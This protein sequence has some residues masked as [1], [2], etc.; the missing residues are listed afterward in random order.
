MSLTDCSCV[1][2]SS[3]V[4]DVTTLDSKIKAGEDAMARLEKRQE[5]SVVSTAGAIKAALAA[6]EGTNAARIEKAVGLAEGN[7]EGTLGGIRGRVE[8]LELLHHD[9]EESNR[10]VDD[11]CTTLESAMKARV[12]EAEAKA[13][14]SD[15][16]ILE[17]IGRFSEQMSTQA[18]V[19]ERKVEM[20]TEGL[21]EQLEVSTGRLRD[22]LSTQVE[23]LDGNVAIAR[24][25]ILEVQSDLQLQIMREAGDIKEISK[26]A[27]T[28][29]DQ[30]ISKVENELLSELTHGITTLRA[31]VETKVSDQD[32]QITTDLENVKSDAAEANARVQEKVTN[33]EAE[34]TGN[35]N[36]AVT[37]MRA[38]IAAKSAAMD[39]RLVKGLSECEEAI[40]KKAEVGF[41]KTLEMLLRQDLEETNEGLKNL[42]KDID[43]VGTRMD[44]IDERMETGEEQQSEFA[45]EFG[46]ME[47]ALNAIEGEQA[48]LREAVSNQI[49]EEVGACKSESEDKAEVLRLELQA[50]MS[51]FIAE[52]DETVTKQMSSRIAESEKAVQLRVGNM[53]ERVNDAASKTELKTQIGLMNINLDEV[54]QAVQALDE[55]LKDVADTEMNELAERMEKVDG[56]YIHN[57]IETKSTFF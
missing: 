52:L 9:T 20:A 30:K 19:L 44:G 42:D 37:E 47:A 2:S 27:T 22:D 31:E 29:Q 28:R 8:R 15:Q 33:L 4:R 40:E 18:N 46:M 23:R 36:E 38:D 14:T 25:E 24:G 12:S 11:R 51:G 5:D 34:L 13:R 1:F 53:E 10:R 50:S 55:M 57:S 49:V 39:A 54:S 45:V 26:A 43:E 32:K 41:V 56:A 17:G 21:K 3:L 16:M 35:T 7:L 6:F 48:E